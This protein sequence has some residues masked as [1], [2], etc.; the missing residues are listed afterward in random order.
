MVSALPGVCL[1]SPGERGAGGEV[2]G[3]MDKDFAFFRSR[4]WLGI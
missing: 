4:N 3:E 1:T 2:V